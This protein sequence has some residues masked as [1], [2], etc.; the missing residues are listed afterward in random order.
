LILPITNVD[1][2]GDV[3]GDVMWSRNRLYILLTWLESKVTPI[4]I[5]LLKQC[6]VHLVHPRNTRPGFKVPHNRSQIVVGVLKQCSAPLW[7]T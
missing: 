5:G 7:S 4:A 3:I 6:L 2:I 1:V